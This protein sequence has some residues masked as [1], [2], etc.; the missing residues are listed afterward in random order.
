MGA[1]T[2]LNEFRV[3][4]DIAEQMLTKADALACHTSQ[5]ERRDSD[6]AWLT[7]ADVA[8]GDFLA[9]LLKDREIFARR[10]LG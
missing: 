4:V 1:R 10:S 9:R 7:L 2:L 3:H 5:M 6:P 8:G